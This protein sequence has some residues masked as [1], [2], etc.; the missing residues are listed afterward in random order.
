M[1]TDE[2]K[3]S[4]ALK[5]GKTA[6]VYYFY[7]EEV[8]LTDTYT[9][10]VLSKTVGESSD[11]VNLVRFGESFTTE[12]LADAV[13]SM[14]LF[15]E[16]KAVLIKDMDCEK[17]SDDDIK[18]I[19]QTLSDVPSECTV[20]FSQTGIPLEALSKKKNKAFIDTLSR[21][22]NTEVCKFSSLT[23]SKIAELIIKKAA[24]NGCSISRQNAIMLS[25]MTL[26]DL[27]LCSNETD[28]LCSYVQSGEIT[29]Q[30]IEK[31]VIRLPDAKAYSIGTAITARDRK[32]AFMLLDE[33][34]SQRVEPIIILSSLSSA[35]IDLYRAMCAKR[36]GRTPEQTASDLSY[37][38]NRAFLVG[39]AFNSVSRMRQEDVRAC[40]LLLK[41]ADLKL[42][43]SGGDG[44]I[45]LE[46]TIAE[47]FLY[48]R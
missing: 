10:R 3:L 15:A 25:E 44:R 28:K 37:P 45:I 24:K 22:G 30:I 42:K 8:F 35:Y 5:G 17:F 27:K 39:K 11:D 21:Q 13:E 18:A 23:S 43:S 20:I 19:A 14:P 40:I 16:H 12:Q 46:Q 48:A 33:L 34:F 6:R 31:L 47:L 36:A 7:G 32:K 29:A 4:A 1:T 38:K 9:K 2:K 41:D 26:N